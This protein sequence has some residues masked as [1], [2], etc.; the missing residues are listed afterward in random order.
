MNN[1]QKKLKQITKG[2]YVR[3]TGANYLTNGGMSNIYYKE[4]GFD[5]EQAI[6]ALTKELIPEKIIVIYGGD[7]M[8]YEEGYNAAIDQFEK[9]LLGGIEL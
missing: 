1:Y 9:N 6:T 2:L 5:T 8:Y 4:C 7:K 3:T